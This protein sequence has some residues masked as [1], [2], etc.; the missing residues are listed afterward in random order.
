LTPADDSEYDGRV[1]ALAQCL[2]DAGEHPR[3]TALLAG[4]IGAMPAGPARAAAHLLLGEGADFLAEEEHLAPAVADSAADPGLPAQALARR[5]A[6]QV[7]QVE[8][9]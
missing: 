4:R 7:N 9:I 2:T 1:L 8:R 3:A 5:A 6:R